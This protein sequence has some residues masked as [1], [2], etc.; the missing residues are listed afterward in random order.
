MIAHE[1]NDT[2]NKEKYLE[3]FFYCDHEIGDNEHELLYGMLNFKIN[4]KYQKLINNFR[5]CWIFGC[6]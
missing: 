3:K 5:N 2:I 6:N 4:Y 1:K